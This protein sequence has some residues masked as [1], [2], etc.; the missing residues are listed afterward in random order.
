MGNLRKNQSNSVLY[1]VRQL[2]DVIF[3]IS[4]FFYSF[5]FIILTDWI[6]EQYPNYT[7][8]IVG[9]IGWVDLTDPE[10]R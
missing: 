4:L 6:L 7:S 1:G 9:I 5:F 8:T 10:V 2:A 3:F